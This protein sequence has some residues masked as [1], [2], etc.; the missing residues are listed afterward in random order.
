M[1]AVFALREVA[2]VIAGVGLKE[3][4][5]LLVIPEFY[6]E[7]KWKNFRRGWGGDRHSWERKSNIKWTET[8]VWRDLT[9]VWEGGQ[10]HFR[11]IKAV[12]I[13]FFY[14]QEED[15]AETSSVETCGQTDL[16]RKEMVLEMPYDGGHGV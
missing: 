5:G 3:A 10:R 1:T 11:L 2:K 7:N 13:Y 15:K 14:R 12:S 8:A 6:L 9:W 4:G 16:S